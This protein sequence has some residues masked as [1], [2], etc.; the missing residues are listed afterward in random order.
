M[1]TIMLVVGVVSVA[2]AYDLGNQAPVK[3]P[4]SYPENIPNPALQGGDTIAN[5]TVISAL[6]YSDSGTTAGYVDNYQATC[7]YAGGAP[8]VVYRYTPAAD[9]LASISLQ[10]SAYD[11]GL[12]VLNSALVQIACNDD[13][14]GLQSFIEVSLTGG[15]TYYIIV[16]GYDAAFGDYILDVSEVIPCVVE[17]PA[18]GG[19]EGE[20]LLHDN[21][22]DNYNGGCNS[23]PDYPFQDL[24]GVWGG[25][26]FTL[27]GVSGWYYSQGFLNRDTDWYLL[28]RP[29][30]GPIDV[31]VDAEYATSIFELGPQD[32]ANVAVIQ[33]TTAGPCQEASMT[34]DNIQS[35]TVWF[36]V[37]PTDWNGL[38]EY[39]YVCWFSGNW[40]TEAEPTTWST[41]KALFE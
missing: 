36:W 29:W 38:Y 19:T 12:F 2:A 7:F 13:S 15:Q 30:S 14:F 34:I 11:T 39:D 24:W 25:G 8:D 18:G 40:W 32:C 10:G 23:P 37:G 27:C 28:P 4:G 41:V 5:A 33:S 3:V 16:D 22:V 6:P 1:I 31:T 9:V 17:C 21:Y 35:Y 26:G 20:P